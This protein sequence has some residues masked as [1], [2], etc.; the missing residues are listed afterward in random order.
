MLT[1]ERAKL[2]TTRDELADKL[3]HK[4]RM[5]NQNALKLQ[6]LKQAHEVRVPPR[7]ARRGSGVGSARDSGDVGGGQRS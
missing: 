2:R 4:E 6:E 3:A 1:E 5:Y 7:C